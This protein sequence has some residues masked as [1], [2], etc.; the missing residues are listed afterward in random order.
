MPK[1]NAHFLVI[2]FAFHDTLRKWNVPSTLH[3]WSF[4]SAQ[5][6]CNSYHP[7]PL[8][9]FLQTTYFQLQLWIYG[10]SS[11]ILS[12]YLLLVILLYLLKCILFCGISG[13]LYQSLHHYLEQGV[14]RV[15]RPFLLIGLFTYE[16]GCGFTVIY[17]VM[18]ADFSV[19]SYDFCC[20]QNE[21]CCNDSDFSSS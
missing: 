16:I 20:N 13:T 3:L 6:Y 18:T 10:L 1:Y 7:L 19:M 12:E 9:C 17:V 2:I 11:N 21:F 15:F 5:K 8:C 4:I 14:N